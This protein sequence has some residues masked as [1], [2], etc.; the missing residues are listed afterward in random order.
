MVNNG[1]DRS[2]AE[3]AVTGGA[4][5]VAFGRP[6]IANPDLVERLRQHAPLNA[7]DKSTFY[8]GGARG[9]TDDPVLAE[10]TAARG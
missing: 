1:Y 10:T 3:A 5:L 9:Y 6:Y 7:P 4:D 2:L 8:G